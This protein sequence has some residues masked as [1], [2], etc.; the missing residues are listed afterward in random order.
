[1]FN[2]RKIQGVMPRAGRGRWCLVSRRVLEINLLIIG[3]LIFVGIGIASLQSDVSRNARLQT[4]DRVSSTRTSDGAVPPKTSA[5]AAKVPVA[6]SLHRDGI[7]VR[8]A[9]LEVALPNNILTHA[10]T[11]VA[12]QRTLHGTTPTIP[13]AVPR[14][15]GNDVRWV[16]SPHPLALPVA[17]GREPVPR[18]IAPPIFTLIPTPP[19]T[20]DP[21]TPLVRLETQTG[22]SP[23]WYVMT[24][25]M[26]VV[27]ASGYRNSRK[28]N[29]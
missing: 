9:V 24:G 22:P 14:I 28:M 29:K 25:L 23:F 19:G 3:A 11:L 16:R 4:Q 1:M 17:I 13:N 26:L 7:V 18:P 10:T 27:F 21:S 6:T 20:V 2:D 15:T 5:S 8:T 12:A